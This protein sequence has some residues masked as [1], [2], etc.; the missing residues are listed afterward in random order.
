VSAPRDRDRIA[1][2]VLPLLGAILVVLGAGVFALATLDVRVDEAPPPVAEPDQPVEVDVA[3][4][5]CGEEP[6]EPFDLFC[7]V[8][9]ALVGHFVDGVE[10][11]VL[12]AGALEGLVEFGDGAEPG[13]DAPGTV[14]CAAPDEAF[15][16]FCESYAHHLAAGAGEPDELVDAAVRGMVEALDDPHTVYVPAH[17]QALLEEE[18]TGEVEGIGALVA[19]R[20]RDDPDQSCRVLSETCVLLV[21]SP[22]AG[23]PAERAGLRAGDRIV[24][25]DGDPVTGETIHE[26]VSRGR[27]PAGTDVV[28]E[29]EREDDVFE[30]TV[31][32]E[33]IAVPYV[34][35]E[36]IEDG[37]GYVRIV[38]FG[39]GSDEG[40]RAALSELL[41]AG[42]RGIVVDLR[43]N[44]GGLT[45][46]T[47]AVASQ[48]L[49]D[50]LVFSLEMGPR[51]VREYRVQPGGVATDLSVEVAVLVNRGTVSA[52]EILAAALAEHDRATLVGEPT[53]GK[54]T[55]QGSYDVAGGGAVRVTVAR[56]IT[57]GGHSVDGTGVQP[58]V[59]VEE[60][61]EPGDDPDRTLQE[62]VEL[63]RR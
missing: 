38:Q 6:P 11:D 52:A 3:V 49:T 50:G 17:V 10:P 59:A 30:V 28:V 57:P 46:P 58:D 15:L 55:A 25:F 34:E 42:A 54:A 22:I 8:Y 1:A 53:F 31:T 61:T 21:V 47:Q 9:G 13:T 7:D 20:D 33:R 36:M 32:R 45:A 35:H 16:A 23:G 12:A 60:P 27:G 39:G 24:S 14:A 29:V 63:L 56:W 5:G 44:P 48:L 51:D 62:A 41:D 18:L 2:L 43:N 40:F 26:A 19:A 37:I 4:T